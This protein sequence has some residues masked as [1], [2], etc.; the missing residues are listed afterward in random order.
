M[1]M[2]KKRSG[3][4]KLTIVAIV[5]AVVVVVAAVAV[6]LT[7]MPPPAPVEKKIKVAVIYTTP[8]EEP[9]NT[10]MHEAMV[11]AKEI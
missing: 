4:S 8:I 7:T 1:D 6:W 9:W 3:I 11:W 2:I 10:V 5:V